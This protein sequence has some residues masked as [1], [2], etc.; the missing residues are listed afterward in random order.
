MLSLSS[1]YLPPIGVRPPDF[2]RRPLRFC[3]FCDPPV[4]ASLLGLQKRLFRGGETLILQIH[5][6]NRSSC[7]LDLAN[8]AV[9][10]LFL[11]PLESMPASNKNTDSARVCR[12]FWW[13]LI[14]GGPSDPQLNKTIVFLKWKLPSGLQNASVVTFSKM[15]HLQ[16]RLPGSISNATCAVIYSTKPIFSEGVVYFWGGIDVFRKSPGEG[17]IGGGIMDAGVGSR[18]SRTPMGQG[19]ANLNN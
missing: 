19:P 4:Q 13:P 2:C 6:L 16:N 18:L 15:S 12:P 10:K 17:D 14:S 9:L 7:C 5:L 3:Y 11:S 1:I 8:L